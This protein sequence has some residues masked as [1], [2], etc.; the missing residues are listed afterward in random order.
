M[1]TMLPMKVAV[2]VRVLLDVPGKDPRAEAAAELAARGLDA[3]ITDIGPPLHIPWVRL[4]GA[5]RGCR[6]VVLKVHGDRQRT[7]DY[8][9]DGSRGYISAPLEWF[10]RSFRPT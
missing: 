7:V 5:K 3:E 2:T 8:A 6:A 4:A 9:Y 10:L 1:A